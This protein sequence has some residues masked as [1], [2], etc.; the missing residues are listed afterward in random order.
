MLEQKERAALRCAVRE[1]IVETNTKERAVPRASWHA[2]R[3]EENTRVV[4]GAGKGK[5]TK[6]TWRM[7]WLR[8]AMKDVASCEKRR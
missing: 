5:K 4:K 8:K 3:R 2:E 7:P 6:G 1:R